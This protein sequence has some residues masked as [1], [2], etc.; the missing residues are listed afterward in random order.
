[1]GLPIT[2]SPSP[3]SP[4]GPGSCRLQLPEP[5]GGC[6]P[7]WVGGELTAAGGGAG[8]PPV[9]EGQG[10]AL[11]KVSEEIYSDVLLREGH[12]SRG[13]VYKNLPAC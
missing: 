3:V 2:G 6:G 11:G 4:P 10:E 5:Q 1:M 9:T 7:S 12:P 8:R 13:S